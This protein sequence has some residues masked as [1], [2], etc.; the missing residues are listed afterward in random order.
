MRAMDLLLEIIFPTY[1]VDSA[2]F[3]LTQ[4]SLHQDIIPIVEN[5]MENSVEFRVPIRTDI[6]VVDRWGDAK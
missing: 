3:N 6:A 5:I 4:V 2:T 1:D